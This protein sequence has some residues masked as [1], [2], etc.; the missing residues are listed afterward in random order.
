MKETGPAVGRRNRR[1]RER[2][3]GKGERTK[4]LVAGPPGHRETG[5]GD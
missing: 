5:N 1:D 3:K 2:G 4:E